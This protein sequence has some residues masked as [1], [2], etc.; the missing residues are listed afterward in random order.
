[1]TPLFRSPPACPESL[2]CPHIRWMIRR[3]MEEVLAIERD[4]FPAPWTEDDFI[5]CLRQR[6]SVGM[7]AE[8]GLAVA[9]FMVYELAPSRLI[10]LNLAVASR[11]RRRGIGLALLNKLRGKLQPEKRRRLTMLVAEHNLDAQLWLRACD[12]RAVRTVR[13][14]FEQ[15]DPVGIEFEWRVERANHVPHLR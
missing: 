2:A 8:V 1:M 9:G 6:N 14:A 3:D 12:V 4:G 10:L 13:N 7:V 11:Y 5:R 15:P